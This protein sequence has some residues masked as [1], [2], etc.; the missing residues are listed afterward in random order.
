MVIKS[1]GLNIKMANNRL[2][3]T[4]LNL[5]IRVIGA[6]VISFTLFSLISMLHGMFGIGNSADKSSMRHESLVEM[7]KPPPKQERQTQQR[8][9]QIQRAHSGA[10]RS[11]DKMAMHFTPDLSID[12]GG[13]GGVVELAQ[14]EFSAEVF[15]EGQT[16]E[17]PRDNYMEQPVYVE[18]V[19]ELNISGIVTAQF[20]ISY[21]GKATNIQITSSPHPL[22]SASVKKSITTA[23]FRPGKNKGIPVNVRVQKIFRF[24]L[25]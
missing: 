3:S 19:R 6:V 15:E 4:F 24:D 14:H 8:I 25:E 22:L 20:T 5:A 2:I 1:P 13:T 7:V 21:E 11:D 9:R 16:D 17:A 18:R 12:A 10:E 23:K